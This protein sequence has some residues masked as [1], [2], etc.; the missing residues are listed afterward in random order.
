M[1]SPNVRICEDGTIISLHYLLY[2][3]SGQMTVVK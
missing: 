1:K 2:E 3:K